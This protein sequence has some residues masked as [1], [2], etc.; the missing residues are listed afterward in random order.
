MARGW[1]HVVCTHQPRVGLT[2]PVLV[3]LFAIPLIAAAPP[4]LVS[5][6]LQVFRTTELNG[7]NADHELGPLQDVC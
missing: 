2:P 4:S 6:S 5:Q 1:L 7:S 3:L